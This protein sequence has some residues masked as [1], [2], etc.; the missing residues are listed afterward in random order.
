MRI[1]IFICIY[2]YIQVVKSAITDIV[3]VTLSRIAALHAYC[4]PP[5]ISEN[6]EK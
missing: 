6:D 3:V 4:L 5:K 2:I 1:Y